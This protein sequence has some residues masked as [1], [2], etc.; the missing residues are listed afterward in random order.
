MRNFSSPRLQSGV[1]TLVIAILL[2]GILSLLV[3]FSANVGLFEMRTGANEQRSN[4]AL[5]AAQHGVGLGLE[6]FRV[7]RALVASR[8]GSGWLVEN[9]RWWE[10]CSLAPNEFPCNTEPDTAA[11]AV[12]FRFCGGPCIDERSFTVPVPQ[13]GEMDGDAFL[14]HRVGALLCLTNPDD[15]PNVRCR[16]EA[17]LPGTSQQFAVRVVSR[18][19]SMT[20]DDQEVLPDSAAAGAV[21]GRATVAQTMST[22][23]LF[24]TGPD[25][26]IISANNVSLRGTFDIVTNPNAGGFGLPI[27]IWSQT[28]IDPNGTPSTCH[29]G[30][31]LSTGSPTFQGSIPVCS[32]CDCPNDDD[33]LLTYK[34][35]SCTGAGNICKGV[36]IIDATGNDL[37][38]GAI[39]FPPDL[40]E[41]MFGY[42]RANYT[43]LKDRAVLL[44]GSMGTAANP[45]SCSDLDAS[46]TGLYWSTEAV[47]ELKNQ[48]GS[49]EFPVL[50]VAE[51]SMRFNQLT[52]FGV[53][54]AFD[55]VPPSMTNNL[56]MQGRSQI[57]G[58]LVS[59]SNIEN[60]TGRAS[61]IYI[62][63]IMSN[64]DFTPGNMRFGA[65]PGSWTDLGEF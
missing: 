7:N 51:E 52:L 8:A 35:N 15:A 49:P 61:V 18:G 38:Y 31:F 62:A 19:A 39:N 43:R 54:Y 65:L 36:D 63:E 33:R 21:D 5:Q 60:V 55:A 41:Y 2:L 42:P 50:V 23:R 57:Y 6:Y 45:K 22:F 30:E 47:C 48:V 40:F 12:M 17:D 32:E 46:S 64:L 59:D 4:R 29:L 9:E 11:R 58:A 37:V 13:P 26:P 10:P 16:S 3:L 25:A 1:T 56:T 28:N 24:A 53:V 44:D 34:D 14:R 27:S 20:T